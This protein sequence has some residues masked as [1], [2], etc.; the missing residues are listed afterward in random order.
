[1]CS[2]HRSINLGAY[3]NTSMTLAYIPCFAWRF[4]RC[5][6]HSTTHTKTNNHSFRPIPCQSPWIRQ[7]VSPETRCLIQMSRRSFKLS[8]AIQ[9]NIKWI[10]AWPL[11]FLLLIGLVGSVV[12]YIGCFSVVQVS[13]LCLEV[14]LSV[15]RL[16]IWAW[17]PT[18]DDGPG[19]WASSRS[20]SWIDRNQT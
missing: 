17:N 2:Q 9:R 5:H 4:H 7:W 18:G 3:N 15:I 12:G 16:A 6:T 1:M 10:H 14:E 8:L 19:P 20:F 11:L 13:C